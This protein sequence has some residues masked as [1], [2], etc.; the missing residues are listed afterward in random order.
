MGWLP[1]DPCWPRHHDSEWMFIFEARILYLR[2]WTTD[3]KQLP[4]T[5]PTGLMGADGTCDGEA[6][7]CI[8]VISNDHSCNESTSRGL[9]TEER[10]EQQLGTPARCGRNH[11][12]G[13]SQFYLMGR[14]RREATRGPVKSSPCFQRCPSAGSHSTGS[15]WQFGV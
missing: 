2:K 4:T 7:Q 9:N 6:A 5:Y 15:A 1:P 10:K 13:L 12:N 14:E 3:G 11:P 8:N